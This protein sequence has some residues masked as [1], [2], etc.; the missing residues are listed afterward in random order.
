VKS[1]LLH[2]RILPRIVHEVI[3]TEFAQG[4]EQQAAWIQS[5][6]KPDAEDLPTD[7]Q[8]EIKQTVTRQLR[9]A[10]HTIGVACEVIRNLGTQPN[11]ATPA[12]LKPMQDEWPQLQPVLHRCAQLVTHLQESSSS[13]QQEELD[14]TRDAIEAVQKKLAAGCTM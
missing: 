9:V 14:G 11:A 5:E 6:S 4:V 10:L 2:E 13:A 12:Q 1:T 8:E 3:L 7:D